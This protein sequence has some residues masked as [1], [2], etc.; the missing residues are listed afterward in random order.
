MAVAV[1]SFVTCGVYRLYW[2]YVTSREIQET[3]E[4]P[5]I[6]PGVDVLLSVLTCGIWAIYAEYRNAQR[7]HGALLSMDP[8][9]KDQSEMVLIL[10][11]AG[12]FSGYVTWV[13]AAYIIQEELNKLARC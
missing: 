6:R 5:E 8:Y 13:V 9:A 2:L 7:I 3:L 4:D 10:N 1:L 11:V 12:L